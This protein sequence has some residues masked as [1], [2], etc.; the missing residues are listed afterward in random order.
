[1]QDLILLSRVASHS[2]VIYRGHTQENLN[3]LSY[4]KEK[5]DPKIHTDLRRTPLRMVLGEDRVGGLSLPDFKVLRQWN[6]S[7]RKN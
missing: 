7:T 5:A 3:G 2:D 1:M 4:R 6:L